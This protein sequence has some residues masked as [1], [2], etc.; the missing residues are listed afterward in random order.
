MGQVISLT[1]Y[2]WMNSQKLL[3]ADEP[4]VLSQT[5]TLAGKVNLLSLGLL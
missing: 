3:S 2:L 1:S 5:L 4:E